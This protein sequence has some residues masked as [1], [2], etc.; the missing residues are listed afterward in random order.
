MIRALLITTLSLSSIFMVSVSA[1]NVPYTHS[2]F[3]RTP[4]AQIP[5]TLLEKKDNSPDLIARQI[6]C[7]LGQASCLDTLCCD[8]S[9]WYVAVI[10]IIPY[11]Q[12]N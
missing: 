7:E 10:F 11:P 3:K 2:L 12:P 5:R 4:G 9:C 1:I 6:T 8:G